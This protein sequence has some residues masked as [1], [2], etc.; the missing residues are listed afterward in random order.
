LMPRMVRI[1]TPGG[2]GSG[3]L[4]PWASRSGLCAIATAAHVINQAFHWE[5]PIRIDQLF[6]HKTLL[7]RHNQRAIFL[8]ENSDTAVI[9]VEKG[10]LEP[11]DGELSFMERERHLRVGADV[12]WLGFPAIAP[13]LC[14]F[15]GRISAWNQEDKSYL[16]DGVAING[17]SGGLVFYL[18]DSPSVVGVLTAYIANRTTGEALP[19]LAIARDVSYLHE[20]ATAFAS[21]DEAQSAQ[22]IPE[23]P[24]SQSVDGAAIESPPSSLS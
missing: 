18:P 22:S 16:I 13:S 10:D 15:S 6:G 1:A 3:F 8:D 17:V 23:A 5:Q 4:L 20:Q 24:S 9:V 12:G 19:G 11:P 14:F 2:Q 21:L 7:A